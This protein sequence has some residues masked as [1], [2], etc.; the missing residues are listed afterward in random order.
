M[1]RLALSRAVTAL[2]DIRFH[3]VPSLLYKDRQRLLFGSEHFLILPLSS[4]HSVDNCTE[5]PLRLNRVSD[6]LVDMLPVGQAV[7]LSEENR[8]SFISQGH[9]PSERGAQKISPDMV[10]SCSQ[11]SVTV[12]GDTS[13]KN[14]Q[15]HKSNQ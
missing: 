14:K 15:N 11:A 5:R 12:P 10:S 13:I 9:L 1:S 2:S 8:C 6:R 3:R 4:P 7:P